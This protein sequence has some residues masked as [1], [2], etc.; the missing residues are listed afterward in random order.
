[1]IEQFKEEQNEIRNRVLFEILSVLSYH[2][3]SFNPLENTTKIPV[4][5]SEKNE[6]RGKKTSPNLFERN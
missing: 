5:Y 3:S 4:N 1:M 6:E 2:D